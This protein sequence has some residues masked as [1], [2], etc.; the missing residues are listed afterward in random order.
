MITDIDEL[1]SRWDVTIAGEDK[2]DRKAIG[3][4]DAIFFDEEERDVLNAAVWMITCDDKDFGRD[5][6]GISRK[7]LEDT[8]FIDRKDREDILAAYRYSAKFRSR[9]NNLCYLSLEDY[10]KTARTKRSRRPRK[11]EPARVF[12]RVK[13]KMVVPFDKRIGA[14]EA[15]GSGGDG[16]EKYRFDIPSDLGKGMREATVILWEV[17]ASGR[18]RFECIFKGYDPDIP[19]YCI[20]YRYDDK[21]GEQESAPAE[22]EPVLLDIIEEDV[23]DD[24]PEFCSQITVSA[25]REIDFS[26]G[27]RITGIG[28][29]QEE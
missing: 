22:Q 8:G 11:P 5:Y 15:K 18:V 2:I 19:F 21:E 17:P 27:I 12:P 13:E 9:L 3:L 7:R 24:D 14:I 23:Y 10:R 16:V 1:A 4:M 25:G 29:K 28:I 20:H 26:R 6:L